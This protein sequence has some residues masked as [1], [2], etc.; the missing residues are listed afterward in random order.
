MD[1]IKSFDGFVNEKKGLS[2]AIYK[3]LK[4]YF[5]TASSP[6][7]KGAQAHLDKTNHGWNLSDEDFEEAKG[8]FKK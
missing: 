8:M 3:S 6:N 5:S 7:M 2:P 1:K 4:D